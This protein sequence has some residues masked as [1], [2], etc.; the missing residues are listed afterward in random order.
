MNSTLSLPPDDALEGC[1]LRRRNLEMIF[2]AIADGIVAVTRERRIYNVNGA[3]ERLLEDGINDLL[4]RDIDEHLSNLT[5]MNLTIA[6]DLLAS[7]DTKL[8]PIMLTLACSKGICR[9]VRVTARRLMEGDEIVGGVLLLH[10]QTEVAQLRESLREQRGMGNIVG[11]TDA[12]R[13][14]FDLVHEVARTDATVLIEGETG[15]GKEL[16]ARAI[17]ERSQRA[18]GPLVT[19]NCAALPENL[20]ESELFGHVKGSFTGATTDRKGRFEIA[21]GGTLFLDEVSEIP[22]SVQVKLLRVLQ[23]H[24]F[25]RVGDSLPHTTNV[26]VISATN[27]RLSDEVAAGRFR[28]D[29]YYRLHVFPIILPPVRDRREDIPL[30]VHAML[31]R[32]ADGDHVPE[33]TPEAL[34]AL[35]NHSWPGNVREM[36][37]AM[38]YALIRSHGNAI[39]PAHLP[40]IVLEAKPEQPVSSERITAERITEA[41]EIHGGSRTKAAE[42]LGISRV[43]L[44]RR[45]KK[46]GL[47]SSNGE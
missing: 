41:L 34:E 6:A 47:D 33:I 25:E 24:T 12:M 16:I 18:D 10:D 43:T 2:D 23:E 21:D 17:H 30:L 4:G 37:A 14:V 13:S 9:L 46:F 29:L 27:R 1:M 32:A 20:L 28:E 15:T 26:R 35:R 31:G 42:S 45:M 19:V 39:E 8:T 7:R 36:Q 3:A 40:P 11:S 5:G 44:W 38:E 22:L